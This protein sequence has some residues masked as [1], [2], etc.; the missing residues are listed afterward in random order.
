MNKDSIEDRMGNLISSS[1]ATKRLIILR[2][3]PGSGR[4]ELAHL[5]ADTYENS[6][7]FATDDFFIEDD[8][9]ILKI[10]RLKE[11]HLWNQER[12]VDAMKQGVSTIIVNNCN[13]QRWEALPYV[14]AA[15]QHNYTVDIQEV[16]TEWRMDVDELVERSNG[17]YRKRYIEKLKSVW[18]DE[19]DV[20]SVLKSVKHNHKL[21]QD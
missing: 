18:E 16:D 6:Q 10:R 15:V 20:D 2:G 12:V 11:A 1:D 17:L 21:K 9:Y 19:Y 13:V 3:L 5:L 14:K 4:H 7:I 8:I